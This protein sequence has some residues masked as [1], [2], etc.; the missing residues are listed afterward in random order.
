[1]H[2][3]L[4]VEDDPE[5]RLTLQ[6]LLQ[7]EGLKVAVA[8]DGRSALDWMVA[9]RPELLLLDWRL[10]DFSGELV[11]AGLRRLHGNSVPVI[12]ITADSKAAE[13]AEVVQAKGF[14]QKPFDLDHLLRMLHGHVPLEPTSEALPR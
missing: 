2:P 12:L 6:V 3:I 8:A 11:A 9:N 10:P 13:K 14:L 7:D 1:M 5:L 4:L